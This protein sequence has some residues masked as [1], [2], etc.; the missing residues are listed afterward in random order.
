MVRK[1]DGKYYRR[2]AR[3]YS[4]LLK[5]FSLCTW[6]AEPALAP[7]AVGQSERIFLKYIPY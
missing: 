7:V 3:G 1:Q 2:D 5:I 4:Y 6:G